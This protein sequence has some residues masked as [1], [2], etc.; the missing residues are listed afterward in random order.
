MSEPFLGEI[1]LFGFSRVPNGWLSCD[2]SL[3]AISV[4]S[5]LYVLLGTTFG[6][7]GQNTFGLPDLRG[8]VPMH[9]GN[10][11][12]LTPRVIG[13]FGGSENV[14]LTQN[15]MPEHGHSITATTAAASANSPANSLLG[16]ISGDALYATD[17]VGLTPLTTLPTASSSSGGGQPHENTMPTL[18]VQ[19]CIATSGIFPSQS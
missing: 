16:A 12:G 1:R 15:Q 11:P 6:G 9:W 7:D 17:V 18:T 14:T 4:Y 8:Q 3:Q 19:Y 10:G 13:Q 5:D 2:G